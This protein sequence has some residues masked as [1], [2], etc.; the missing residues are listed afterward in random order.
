VVGS[1]VDITAQLANLQPAT[2]YIIEMELRCCG[3][4]PS[5]TI[6]TFKSAFFEL[7]GPLVYDVFLRQGGAGT[8]CDFLG[9]NAGTDFPGP[10]F[11]T[12]VQFNLEDL[13][14]SRICPITINVANVQ[15]PDNSNLTVVLNRILN[16]DPIGQR[17][18]LWTQNV[19]IPTG[20]IWQGSLINQFTDDCR[21]YEVV[22]SYQGCN[23]ALQT[24]RYYFRAGDN[25]T[26]LRD[27]DEVFLKSGI[28]PQDVRILPNPVTDALT[29]DLQDA[30]F[31][32]G[33]L[34]RFSIFDL[35]GRVVHSAEFPALKGQIQ[36]N[37]GDLKSGTYIYVVEYGDHRSS[38]KF[39]KM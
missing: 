24:D 9:V 4:S 10:K 16:C 22:M 26:G 1:E 23:N 3:E 19:V 33:E 30:I 36:Q 5:C 32:K 15:N 20:G 12:P 39:V 11:L 17:Q 6:N 25:C 14:I 29:L 35:Y 27:D 8:N 31:A 28:N 7:R 37:V 13:E 2:T 38:G 18:Q 34:M 21:C